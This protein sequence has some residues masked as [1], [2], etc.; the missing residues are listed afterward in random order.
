ME[1]QIEIKGKHNI[2]KINKIKNPIRNTIIKN[3]IDEKYYDKQNQIKLL[4]QIY[5][6]E[7]NDVVIDENLNTKI[8]GYKQQDLEKQ[9]F[10]TEKIINYNQL[11]EQLMIS[12]LQC[13]YCKNHCMLCY[14]NVR[15]KKQWTLDRIN[16][17]IGHNYDN[18]VISCLECNLK[19]RTTDITKYKKSKI[20]QFVKKI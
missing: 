18:V 4:N 20:C 7:I 17:D 1:K 19:R 5:L 11:V 14:K 12:K 3:P 2:D 9:I 6:N 8:R 13:Y 16:N 10:N 15:E